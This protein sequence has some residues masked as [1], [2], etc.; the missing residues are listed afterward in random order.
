MYYMC[1][2]LVSKCSVQVLNVAQKT[3]QAYET[4]SYQSKTLHQHV[5]DRGFNYIGG[6]KRVK[7]DSWVCQ[8]KDG[9]AKMV[10]KNIVV[11]KGEERLGLEMTSNAGDNVERSRNPGI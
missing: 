5:L 11:S 3:P 4:D 2:K 7:R 6:S 10:K 8:V 9:V 1:T